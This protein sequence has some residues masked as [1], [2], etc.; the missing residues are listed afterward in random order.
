[1]GYAASRDAV[2]IDD[3][4]WGAVGA[5][6]GATTDKITGKPERGGIGVGTVEVAGG[7]FTAVAAVNAMGIASD[8]WDHYKLQRDLLQVQVESRAGENTTLVVLLV[9]AAIDRDG[10][11]QLAVSAH[12]GMARA[13][14]P[15]HTPFDGDLV[16]VAGL[17]DADPAISV[18]PVHC[19]AAEMAVEQ[20]IHHAVTLGRSSLL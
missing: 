20:A 4:A 14:L 18:S 6:R 19:I 7:T 2:A 17:V 1:M 11:A 9:N 16:F 5:G 8:I 3:A 15:C 12:D 13:I 10:L